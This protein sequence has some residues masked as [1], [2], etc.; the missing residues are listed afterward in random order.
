[1]WRVPR[2]QGE[3]Y[4]KRYGWR[5]HYPYL[6]FTSFLPS[7]L[8]VC[9]VLLS[10]LSRMQLLSLSSLHFTTVSTCSNNLLSGSMMSHGFS[11]ECRIL[12]L[13]LILLKGLV[14]HQ[15]SQADLKLLWCHCR[16]IFSFLVCCWYTSIG[17]LQWNCI[18]ISIVCIYEVE[19]SGFLVAACTGLTA[20]Y[21]TILFLSKR[22]TSSSF[23]LNFGHLQLIFCYILWYK[24]LI[25]NSCVKYMPP[26]PKFKRSHLNCFI[27]PC[28]AYSLSAPYAI[29]DTCWSCSFK[30]KEKGRFQ[31][32]HT[33]MTTVFVTN[34][35][36]DK[37]FLSY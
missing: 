12:L 17:S 14:K 21:C 11:S 33:S 9:S 28:I 8:A 7:L 5:Y 35:E 4:Q 16:L 20:Q 25:I 30:S 19:G 27:L 10:K 3:A 36:T 32:S 15:L 23:F 26:S 6:G 2:L 13:L 22:K 29:K 34:T 37:Y 1:V 24:A 18:S 31:V